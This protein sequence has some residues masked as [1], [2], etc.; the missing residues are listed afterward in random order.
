MYELTDLQSKS[1]EKG[2]TDGHGHGNS[3]SSGA[4]VHKMKTK[5]AGSVTNGATASGA[6]KKTCQWLHK[7]QCPA[8]RKE[9]HQCGN[10]NHFAKVCKAKQRSK[11]PQAEKQHGKFQKKKSVK[12]IETRED[13][14]IQEE[15]DDD[16]SVYSMYHIQSVKSKE[17]SDKYE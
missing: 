15:S 12:N 8:F 2:L 16:T 6:G 17:S 14:D 11:R 3:S 1:I 5:L 10:K 13:S 4:A 9:C 7:G